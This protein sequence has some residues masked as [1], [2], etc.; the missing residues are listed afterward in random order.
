MRQ[1]LILIS[2]ILC[3]GFVQAQ[4]EMS[5]DALKALH[6]EKQAA[7]DALAGEA[8]DLQAKID[9]YPGWKFG[10]YGAIGFDGIRNNNWFSLPDPNSQQGALN[11][12]F[13]G[14]AR[15]DV[16]KHFWHN[17]LGISLARVSAFTDKDD[18]TSESITLTNNSLDLVSLYGYKIAPKW[19]ISAE[20][21]WTSTV[22]DSDGFDANGVPN[23]S[24]TFNEP[25]QATLSAGITWLPIN[26][27][28]VNI[29]PIGYQQNW[30]GT[31]SSQAGA[32]I[33]AAYLAEIF[34][35]VG[36]KSD[37]TAFIPYSGGG[38]RALPFIGEDE[39]TA[40][41]LVD[42]STSD[43]TNWTWINSFTTNIWKGIGVKF[44]IG[45]G[46]NRQTADLNRIGASDVGSPIADDNPFQSYFGLGLAYSFL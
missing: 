23:F 6:A 1:L 19:A 8:A 13:G 22:L 20:L 33:G 27:L 18:D 4:E 29:H 16:A 7:A 2:L 11:L 46:T 39:D 45:L 40:S 32:K 26:N 25:G 24:L 12:G 28:T 43:L 30:P 44:D 15:L 37:L 14:T 34:P 21:R 17:S 41:G 31:L 3:V 38:T 5:L 9:K 42:Y 35:G 10:A 36:W